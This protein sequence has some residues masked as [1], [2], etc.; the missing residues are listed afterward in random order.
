MGVVAPLAGQLEEGYTHVLLDGA[1]RALA[2]EL[3]RELEE[4]PELI[5]V[6]EAGVQRRKEETQGGEGL[7]PDTARTRGPL[8][9]RD[10]AGFGLGAEAP[11]KHETTDVAGVKTD[12]I[13]EGGETLHLERGGVGE[14]GVLE[15]KRGGGH[16]EGGGGRGGLKGEEEGGEDEGSKGVI[17]REKKEES[18]EVKSID[19]ESQMYVS[20]ADHHV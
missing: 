16:D 7:G 14:G 4:G 5:V 10:A 9:L 11:Q 3:E 2:V 12:L 13:E 18:S 19:G 15:E 6:H 20:H 1:V 8:C 17:D